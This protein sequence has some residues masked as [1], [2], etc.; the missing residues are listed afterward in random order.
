MVCRRL[1]FRIRKNASTNCLLCNWSEK[2]AAG[3]VNLVWKGKPDARERTRSLQ[4]RKPRQRRPILPLLQGGHVLVQVHM[5]PNTYGARKQRTRAAANLRTPY[6]SRGNHANSRNG[7]GGTAKNSTK[8]ISGEEFQE[9]FFLISTQD[10]VA[11]EVS[12]NNG[13]A[14]VSSAQLNAG[15][16]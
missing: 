7:S 16:S 1:S 5:N 14:F 2:V 6:P 3:G 9:R 15:W 10:Q 12:Q 4:T 8:R 13:L 11:N